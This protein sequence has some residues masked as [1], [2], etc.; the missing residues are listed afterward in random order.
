[1][2]YSLTLYQT[3]VTCTSASQ[4]QALVLR[5]QLVHVMLCFPAKTERNNTLEKEKQNADKRYNFQVIFTNPRA[6]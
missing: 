4:P 3:I 6:F 5:L 1:M 2:K